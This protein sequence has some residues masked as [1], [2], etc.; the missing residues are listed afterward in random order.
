[1]GNNIHKK[2]AQIEKNFSSLPSV[3]PKPKAF[4]LFGQSNKVKTVGPKGDEDQKK[5][6]VHFTTVQHYQENVFIEGNRPQYLEDLHTEAQEGLK[7][8][9]REEHKN[10][11]N[12]PDDGNIASTDTVRPE[13]DVGSRDGGDAPGL[14]STGGNA[15]A[16]ITCAVSTRPALSHQSSTF[17][18]L[19]PVKSFDKGRKRCRRT[20]IMGIPNQVQKELALHKSSTFQQTVSSQVRNH[21]DQ[22]ND[23]QSGSAIIPT[24]DGGSP[25]ANKEGMRV[26]LS[27]LEASRDVQTA[28][29]EKHF[30]HQRSGNLCPTFVLRPKSVAVPGADTVPSSAPSAMLSF[31][32]ELQG[33]VMSISPQAT[34]LSTIIP[35]AVLPASID[36]IEIDRSISRPCGSNTN[37]AG[38][39]RTVSKS[40]LGSGDSGSPVLSRRA[41]G[42]GFHI[43]NSFKSTTIPA[44]DSRLDWNQLQPSRDSTQHSS[45]I[46]SKETRASDNTQSTTLSRQESQ[47]EQPS[48]NQNLLSVHDS[49]TMISNSSCKSENLV[50]YS[51]SDSAVSGP[52]AAGE[53]KQN[54]QTCSRSLSVVK[55]KLPPP[56]PQRTNSL[57]SNKTRSNI[58]VLVDSKDPK[59]SAYGYV[60]AATESILSSDEITSVT[61]GTGKIHTNAT[62]CAA[63]SS[64]DDSRSSAS[65]TFIPIKYSSG[66]AGGSAEPQTESSSSSAQK[67][68]LEGAKFERT[69][70]PSSGYSSQSG[71]PTLSPKGISPTSPDKQKRKPVK[72]ERS[73]SRASS[74]ASPSSSLTSLSCSTSEPVSQDV[75]TSSPKESPPDVAVKTL[76][77]NHNSSNMP[78][79]MRELLKIPPPPKVR[80]PCAPPPETWIHNKHTFDLLCGSYPNLST[81]SHKPGQTEDNTVKQAETQTET[82]DFHILPKKKTTAEKPLGQL[83]DK[84][85]SLL[86]ES[87]HIELQGK[88]GSADQK[89][90]IQEVRESVGIQR[91]DK[92]MK[93]QETSP[94]KCPPPVMKK[95]TV[96]LHKEEV[97]LTEKSVERQQKEVCGS[98]LI[99]LHLADENHITSSQNCNDVLGKG[100]IQMDGHEVTSMQT[101]SVEIPKVP[102]VSPPPTPPPAYHPT[103]PPSRKSPPSSVSTIPSE[104]QR[105]QEDIHGTESCWPPPPPPLEGDSVFDGGDEIDFPPPPPFISESLLDIV[106]SY[107]AGFDVTNKPTVAVDVQEIIQDSSEANEVVNEQNT[108]SCSSQT[109]VNDIKPDG[110]MKV[111]QPNCADDVSQTELQNALSF[112]DAVP[113]PPAETTSSPSPPAVRAEEPSSPSALDTPSCFLKPYS[114]KTEESS[115]QP[116]IE[117]FPSPICDPVPPTQLLQNATP[118]VN[119]RRHPSVATRDSSSKE[120]HFRHKSI[121]VSKEDANIP[122]VTPSLLQMVRLRTVNM[123]EDQVNTPSTEESTNKEAPI[124]ETCPVSSPASQNIPQKPI[125]KSLSLKSSPQAGKTSS[126]MLNMPSMRLQEAIRMKTAAMSSR[127]CV[128]PRLGLRSSSCMS[129]PGT[130]FLKS[131]EGYDLPKSPASTASFIFSKSIKKVVIETVADPSPDAQA[132]LKQS[133]VAELMQVAGQSKTKVYANG[134][135][136]SDKVPPPVAKKPTH[137]SGISNV[138][139]CSSKTDNSTEGNGD[140]HVTQLK[141]TTTRVTADTIETLF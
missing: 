66:E 38:S 78:L 61:S 96:V 126:V 21:D 31:L 120:L 77:T 102:K 87:V 115:Q 39:V 86:T 107:I 1:M 95:P 20:T 109:A 125:R 56:P 15:D 30:N 18:P 3:S 44:S 88:K 6:S 70:S 28:H 76:I 122:L 47:Q 48:L 117:Q 98:I 103:P 51:N 84:T 32:Q 124:Q 113:N 116:G 68:L 127:D 62:R 112:L 46:L 33:P 111:S 83:T 141:E 27:E 72:P 2:K 140:Q 19:N 41:D 26:H 11:V 71:T 49:V 130:P 17:K 108:D 52:A 7:I 131:S 135:V 101:L 94:K 79:E 80:A 73:V 22:V 100:E 40:S 60:E 45:P 54:K 91:Q 58:R 104:I 13:Q 36:V 89:M 114:I 25:E 119:F 118:G 53:E 29:Q 92:D 69:M 136:N 97:G 132:S 23:R 8:Q 24:L 5:L 93:S 43:D 106:D 85:G 12:A 121:P 4:W 35:N 138:A 57:H 75:S 55:P 90:S 133:L 82:G 74:A 110:V 134:G 129:E 59:L 123:T 14:K 16:T 137:V 105:V 128:P 64:S 10:G 37:Q 9:Q 50:T 42:D 63:S 139:T 65:S 99:E 81:P 34:Y 67:T